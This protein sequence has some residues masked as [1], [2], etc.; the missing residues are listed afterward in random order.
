MSVFIMRRQ[1]LRIVI[2]RSVEARGETRETVCRKTP[3]DEPFY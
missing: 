3:I 1:I 2:L